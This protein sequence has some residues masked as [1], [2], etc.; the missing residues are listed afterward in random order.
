MMRVILL[1]GLLAVT[2][3]TTAGRSPAVVQYA[4]HAPALTPV[5]LV[6]VL[7]YQHQGELDTFTQGQHDAR[8]LF[9]GRIL[10][11][12]E[13]LNYFAPSLNAYEKTMRVLR[14]GGFRI[15]RTYA[16]R[17]LIDVVAPATTVERVFNT[18]LD[19]AQLGRASGYASVRRPEIPSMLKESVAYVVGFNSLP[20]LKTQYVLARHG[21]NKI[22]S[23]PANL[24]PDTGFGPGAFSLAYDLPSEHGFV[25]RGQ[26]IAIVLDATNLKS[27]MEGFLRYFQIHRTGPATREIPING[28]PNP[29]FNAD[30]VE[31]TLDSDTIVGLAPAVALYIYEP[32]QLT[33]S[34]TIDAYS[35]IDSDDLVEAVNSSFG[36]CEPDTTDNFPQASNELAE[37]GAALGIVYSASSGDAGARECSGSPQRSALSPASGPNFTSVGGTTLFV[38]PNGSYWFEQG[39]SGSGGGVSVEFPAPAYQSVL[40]RAQRPKSMRSVPDVAFD[41]DPGSGLGFYFEGRWQGP[42]GGT[43]LASP[44]FSAFVAESDEHAGHRLSGFNVAAY[45]AL[46][47]GSYDRYFHDIVQGFNGYYFAAKGYDRVTGLGSV[48]GWAFAR[49][50]TR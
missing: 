41:A 47:R 45:D 10:T 2:L 26:S 23:S 7:K 5:S 18:T 14:A 17:T 30:S 4:G 38:K 33:L 25:G 37:Q 11:A 16:N 28:G 29:A 50:V 22:S 12:A 42:I 43:S 6:V 1:S 27:D 9:A 48:D 46:L 49:E 21:L 24:A 31:A 44:I 36:L 15:E 20:V 13:F 39:W 34:S 35:Q 19:R 3:G 8:S 40:S 32:N